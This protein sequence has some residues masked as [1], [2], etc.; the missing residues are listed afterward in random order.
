MSDSLKRFL[1]VTPDDD[2]N[3]ANSGEWT[4]VIVGVAGNL[5]F[6]TEN[7]STVVLPL[8]VGIHAI[9]VRRIRATDTTATGLFVAAA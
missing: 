3:L 6:D 1:A 4:H 5:S 8:P 2:N 9:A 7:A